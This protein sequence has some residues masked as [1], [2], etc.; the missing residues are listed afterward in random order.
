MHHCIVQ[1]MK[2]NLGLRSQSELYKGVGLELKL[3]FDVEE[4]DLGL[5]NE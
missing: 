3:S 2:V 5:F 1:Y 4:R